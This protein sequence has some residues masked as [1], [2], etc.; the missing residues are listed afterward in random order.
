MRIFENFRKTV[1]I[2]TEKYW[3]TTP[4]A[5]NRNVTHSAGCLK[6]QTIYEKGRMLFRYLIGVFFASNQIHL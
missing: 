3:N 1:Y 4:V 2:Y 5:L 6:I